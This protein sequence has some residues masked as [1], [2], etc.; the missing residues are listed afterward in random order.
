M[1]QNDVFSSSSVF[2]AMVSLVTVHQVL[3]Q[4]ILLVKFCSTQVTH[5]YSCLKAFTGSGYR[6]DGKKKKSNVPSN[7]VPMGPP[8]I[9]RYE[10]GQWA[11]LLD[12]SIN[13]I[14]V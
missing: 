14:V 7:P 13:V 4:V 9:K 12:L 11:C 2:V 8:V 10:H 6:L 5:L 1:R 3:F